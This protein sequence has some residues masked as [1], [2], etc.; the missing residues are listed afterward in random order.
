[1][2]ALA[3]QALLAGL[4]QLAQGQGAE[5]GTVAG[6]AGQRRGVEEGLDLVAEALLVAARQAPLDAVPPRV[7]G[8]GDLQ[9]L[10]G[11]LAGA[12]EGL[13]QP[14]AVVGEA[15]A[16][17]PGHRV[18][19]GGA[20]G[21]A[22]ELGGAVN[23]LLEGERGELLEDGH[24]VRPPGGVGPSKGG[25]CPWGDIEAYF[26]LRDRE[27]RRKVQPPRGSPRIGRDRRP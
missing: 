7:A 6:Q 2:A 27:L 5:L 3:E 11:G 14:L 4:A 22:E 16:E 8:Q 20:G 23:D 1:E 17:Q 9:R 18:A 12:L 15:L 21:E 24:G 13:G 25:R 26:L 19:D 10:P